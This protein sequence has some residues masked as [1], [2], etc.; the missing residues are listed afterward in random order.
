MSARDGSTVAGGPGDRALL[1]AGGA[2]PL[3]GDT[4]LV[5]SVAEGRRGRRWRWAILRAGAVEHAVLL[6]VDPVGR[7]KRLEATGASGLLTLHPE[8]DLRSVHGNL[9]TPNGIEH[10]SLGWTPETVFDVVD[11]FGPFVVAAALGGR[12]A[13]GAEIAV[14]SIGLDRF[15]R[16]VAGRV[17]LRRGAGGS[18][19]LIPDAPPGLRRTTWTGQLDAAGRPELPAG[20]TWPLELD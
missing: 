4:R 10:L 12:L 6:E 20:R 7:P 18:W 17:R 1:R 19:S 13:P 2:A 5:W 8:P 9:V 11:P 16:P 14:P 3:A 15:L